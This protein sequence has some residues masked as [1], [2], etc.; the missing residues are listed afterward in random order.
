MTAR[1]RIEGQRRLNLIEFFEEKAKEPPQKTCEKSPKGLASGLGNQG[2]EQ[3]IGY[4]ELK[5]EDF[6]ALH[7]R[8]TRAWRRRW[9]RKAVPFCDGPLHVA[10]YQRKP[11]G[12]APRRGMARF[13]R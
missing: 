5:V 6:A 13:S 12:G 11:R 8:R 1:T 9:Q 7:A 2:G 4:L 3:M 10:N